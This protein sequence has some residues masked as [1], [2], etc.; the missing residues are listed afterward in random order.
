MPT[1][2]LTC[3]EL[4]ELVTDYLEG[5]LRPAERA[6]FEAHIAHCEHCSMYLDQMRTTIRLVGTLT[7]ESL[8]PAT[9]KELLAR[10]RDWK[11]QRASP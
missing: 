8:S 11:R 7:S 1:E 4:V 10:F 3:Q 6:R 9:Q 5:I 2:T